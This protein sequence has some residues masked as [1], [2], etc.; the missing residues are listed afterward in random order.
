MVEKVL[1]CKNLPKSSGSF[2]IG[3]PHHYDI[4]ERAVFIKMTSEAIFGRCVVQ[5]TQEQFPGTLW[6]SHSRIRHDS[7]S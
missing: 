7:T 1:F 6:F 3:K 5:A 4:N 2:G